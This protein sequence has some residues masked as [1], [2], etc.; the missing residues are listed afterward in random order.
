MST[1]VNKRQKKSISLLRLRK[2]GLIGSDDK[3]RQM[4]T[5]GCIVKFLPAQDGLVPLA[6]AVERNMTSCY[7]RYDVCTLSKYVQTLMFLLWNL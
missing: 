6:K 7:V 1:L 2:E 5:M 3:C 4:W